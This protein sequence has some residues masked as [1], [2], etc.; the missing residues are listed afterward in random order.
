[1]PRRK[2]SV[3]AQLEIALGDAEVRSSRCGDAAGI[4]L[5]NMAWLASNMVDFDGIFMGFSWIL[6][7]F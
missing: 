7:G 5:G 6:M 2:R 4:G 1:L 3:Q